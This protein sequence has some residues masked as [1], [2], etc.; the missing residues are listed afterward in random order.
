MRTEHAP[1]DEKRIDRLQSLSTEWLGRGAAVG[2][3]RT[4]EGYRIAVYD[5]WGAER[6]AVTREDKRSALGASIRSVQKRIRGSEDAEG[7]R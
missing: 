6:L 3:D 7:S 1:D 5:L 2:I 4:P